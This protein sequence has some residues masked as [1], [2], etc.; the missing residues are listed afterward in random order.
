MGE[1]GVSCGLPVKLPVRTELEA[2]QLGQA[3][4]KRSLDSSAGTRHSAATRLLWVLQVALCSPHS[5]QKYIVVLTPH[6]F[7]NV[8][9]FRGKVFTEVS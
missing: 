3:A 5:H 1:P 4:W 8:I 7:Q 9:L 6:T 2:G